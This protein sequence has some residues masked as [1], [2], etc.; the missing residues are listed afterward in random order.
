[1]KY[2]SKGFTLIELLIVIS[3]IGILS[4]IV[5][6]NLS[7]A[8]AKGRDGKRIS[9]ISQIRLAL[10]LY[11]DQNSGQYPPDISTSIAPTYMSVVPKDPSTGSGYFYS[12]I[13]TASGGKYPGFHLGA[14]LETTNQVLAED[15][16]ST[17]GFDGTKD[18][19]PSSGGTASTPYALC[20]DV[21]NQ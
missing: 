5:L 6:T 1:M 11:A 20:Y 16:N 4:S 18:A 10:E 14:A 13:G 17:S 12:G 7:T 21:V 15:A 8:R 9:D 2:Y 19:C 3:I